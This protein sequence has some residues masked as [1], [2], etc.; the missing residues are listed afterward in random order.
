MEV[1]MNVCRV[2]IVL[3]FA[4]FS[5]VPAFAAEQ[6]SA[7][8]QI[9]AGKGLIGTY[10]N[11]DDFDE[12]EIGMID[13][14][15]TIDYDWGGD[16]GSDWSA[17]WAGFI[18]G[19]VTDQV[20]LVAEAGDGLRL[21]LGNKIVIDSLTEGGPRSG[22]VNMLKGKKEPIKLELT[23]SNKKALLRLYWQWAG[24]EKEIIPA[25]ALS[26]STEGLPKEFMVFDF[27]NR[28]SDQ[29]GGDD[30]DDASYGCSMKADPLTS[31]SHPATPL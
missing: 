31:I 22:K 12:P 5:T 27:D 1:V 17:R 4:V 25:S 11:S 28:P 10:Y 26:H 13:I 16:R 20:T 19:P 18:E 2:L 3:V 7:K 9:I 29:G 14:L 8:E 6:M 23:S 15:T 30:D 24:K 21:T